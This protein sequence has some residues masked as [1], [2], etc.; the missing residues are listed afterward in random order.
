MD[1]LLPNSQPETQLFPNQ[2]VPRLCDLHENQQY[3][4]LCTD[5][6]RTDC[7]FKCDYCVVDQ[8]LQGKYLIPISQIQNAN[9]KTVFWHWPLPEDSELIR[10]IR[11]LSARPKTDAKYKDLIDKYF[12]ELRI[13]ILAKIDSVQEQMRKQSEQLWDFDNR[14]IEQYNVFCAKETL[15]KIVFD[16]QTALDELSTRVRE[17][18]AG[19]VSCKEATK[20]AL[21]ASLS[22]LALQE[23]AVDFEGPA[24]IKEEVLHKLSSISMFLVDDMRDLIASEAVQDRGQ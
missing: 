5:P 11:A 8:A 12:K 24:K 6:S 4:L 15:K 22:Q 18:T 14:I 20:T 16:S 3:T 1:S 7:A 21:E 10:Q 13:E 19:V 23:S 17:T 9:S 2:S